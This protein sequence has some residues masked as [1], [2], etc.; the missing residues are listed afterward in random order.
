MSDDIIDTGLSKLR[1]WFLKYDTKFNLSPDSSR[2]RSE[3]AIEWPEESMEF[4][5]EDQTKRRY[6]HEK[7]KKS[8]SKILPPNEYKKRTW[9]KGL[10]DSIHTHT[11]ITWLERAASYIRRKNERVDSD[12][13][14]A[15]GEVQRAIQLCSHY[16]NNYRIARHLVTRLNQLQNLKVASA[17]SKAKKEKL[18]REILSVMLVLR[19]RKQCSEE[20]SIDET[21]EPSS[22]EGNNDTQA[23]ETE[24]IRSFGE[25]HD[26]YG[27]PLAKL[28]SRIL[29]DSTKDKN[30]NVNIE[31]K[32]LRD[33]QDFCDMK[34]LQTI[35]QN[36]RESGADIMARVRDNDENK[37]KSIKTI[38]AA[39][40]AVST[41]K[42]KKTSDINFSKWCS[43][44]HFRNRV[45]VN[46]FFEAA[47]Q[48]A[49][50]EQKERERKEK[51]EEQSEVEKKYIH[52]DEDE[53][54]T[55][56]P[57]LADE[58]LDHDDDA[59][60]LTPIKSSDYISGYENAESPTLPPGLSDSK[61]L[62]KQAMDSSEEDENP[63]GISKGTS[64]DSFDTL[65][66]GIKTTTTNESD[67]PGSPSTKFPEPPEELLTN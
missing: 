54:L 62:E 65:P 16:E 30:S 32:V 23:K 50:E 10:R 67:L 12:V 26:S 2:R 31:D 9:R 55:N 60:T 21:T 46:R 43:T 52:T 14:R 5:E 61:D 13:A 22:S 36:N 3:H 29:W 18:M 20:E 49:K 6:R 45:K 27:R 58:K 48:H 28:A 40:I 59:S 51:F 53:R 11:E 39:K 15:A 34:Y 47:T 4:R 8:T 41:F 64:I 25:R 19:R 42:K 66:P 17:M 24:F 35:A 63:P 37:K 1:N 7:I 57:G 38:D 44:K 56:P 33:L